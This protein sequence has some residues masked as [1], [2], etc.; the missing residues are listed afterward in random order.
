MP[1]NNPILSQYHLL[2]AYAVI[3]CVE[4]ADKLH[5][6]DICWLQPGVCKRQGYQ[7]RDSQRVRCTTN[8]T[9]GDAIFALGSLQFSTEAYDSWMV[10]LSTLYG[11]H[12][13][14]SWNTLDPESWSLI[15]CATWLKQCPN[16]NGSLWSCESSPGSRH[17]NH[18]PPWL[19]APES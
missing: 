14:E 1:Q 17:V 6:K 15:Q 9:H 5:S 11:V 4:G 3:C 2:F 8:V 19:Y 7:L 16:R 18:D 12:H 10:L 13:P